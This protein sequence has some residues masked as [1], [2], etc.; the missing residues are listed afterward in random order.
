MFDNQPQHRRATYVVVHNHKYAQIMRYSKASTHG[1]DDYIVYLKKKIQINS[2][3]VWSVAHRHTPH[4]THI[5]R[6]HFCDQRHFRLN[7]SANLRNTYAKHQTMNWPFQRISLWRSPPLN[8]FIKF[9]FAHL[10][11]W[12]FRPPI[13]LNAAE[14]FKIIV[15]KEMKGWVDIHLWNS[16]LLNGLQIGTT[17]QVSTLHIVLFYF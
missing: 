1:V 12:T 10:F 14:K 6:D 15:D 3:V 9:F 16:L 13:V 7:K 17:K 5:W 4:T 2:V 8:V 11:K